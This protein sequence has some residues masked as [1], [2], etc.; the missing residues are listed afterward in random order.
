[1]I[2]IDYIIHCM[3]KLIKYYFLIF[4]C[5]IQAEPFQSTYEPLPAENT[6]IRYANIYDGEGNEFL[7]TDLLIQ[8]RMFYCLLKKMEVLL[9]NLAHILVTLDQALKVF[10]EYIEKHMTS[11]Q[12]C[13]YMDEARQ[14]V[15]GY[16]QVQYFV[17]NLFLLHKR[18][19][20]I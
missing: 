13:C 10:F 6:L 19:L 11:L 18:L 5:F 15:I 14:A 7:E 20:M 12:S 8:N 2:I 3:T 9:I 1:M 16:E 4:A 17:I